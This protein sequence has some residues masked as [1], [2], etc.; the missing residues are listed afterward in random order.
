MWGIRRDDLHLTTPKLQHQSAAVSPF[1]WTCTLGAHIILG[2]GKLAERKEE[3]VI[4]IAA[5][6]RQ[7]M[8][9]E[10]RQVSLFWRGESLEPALR[11]DGLWA[12][13]AYSRAG[14]D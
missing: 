9:C 1:R 3:E 10:C 14:V 2:G 4:G 7:N 11:M 5:A 6:D 8:M 13:R 12:L